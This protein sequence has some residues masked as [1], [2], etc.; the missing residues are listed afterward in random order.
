[1]NTNDDL[2][3]IKGLSEKNNFEEKVQPMEIRWTDGLL[4][5][6]LF[7]NLNR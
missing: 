7:Y 4:S 6:R 1:M 5:L 2:R 3:K